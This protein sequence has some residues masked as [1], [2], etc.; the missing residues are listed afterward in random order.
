MLTLHLSSASEKAVKATPSGLGNKSLILLSTNLT[1]GV[2]I[3]PRAAVPGK[4]E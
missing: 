4:G 2:L 1:N 3:L